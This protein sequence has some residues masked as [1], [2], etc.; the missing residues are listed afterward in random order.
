ML[1]LL[2]IYFIGKYFYKLAEEFN[3]NKW[4]YAIL[5]IVMYYAAGFAFGILLGVFDLLLGLNL[6][7]DNMFGI[8]LLSIPIGL[9]ACYGF[10]HLLKKKWKKSVVLIKDEIQDI[11]KPV[12]EL[13]EK[14]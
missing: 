12:E 14:N 4:L 6:D 10:Y 2:L 9:A 7:Y 1:G 11:G 5:G 13:E 3:Q 8:N